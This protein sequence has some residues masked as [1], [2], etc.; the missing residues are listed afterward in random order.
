VA[1]ALELFEA[2]SEGHVRVY[3]SS[4]SSEAW[5]LSEG[6]DTRDGVVDMVLNFE[7]LLV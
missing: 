2:S 5:L 7:C 4:T 6:E 1:K 3:A